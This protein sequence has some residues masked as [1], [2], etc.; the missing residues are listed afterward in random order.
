MP[1]TLA[2][3]AI[4]GITTKFLIRKSDYLWIYL[5]CII[6]DFPWILRRLIQFISPSINGYFLQSYLIIQAS[7][8]V[9]ILLGLIFSFTS[10]NIYRTFLI[11]SL[12]SILHLL[13]DPIQIKWANGVHLFAPFSW[14]L[15][16]YGIFWPENIITYI[17]TF[18]GLLFFLININSSIKT[19]FKLEITLN[20]IILIL[21][22]S[23]IYFL[24]PL[25]FIQNIKEKDCH[26]VSTLENVDE[27]VGKYA[28]F[29]RKSVNYDDFSNNYWIESF[30][31][32]RIELL[33]IKNLA[34]NNVSVKGRFLTEN[35]FYVEEFHENWEIFRDGASY[36]GI[37]LISMLWFFKILNQFK[38]SSKKSSLPSN[39]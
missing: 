12:G 13:L 33:N 4:N 24:S 19:K 6:P 21:L 39:V 23:T 10:K 3:I 16:N 18:S 28:E 26:F 14:E 9:S 5:G 2:H 36:L 29:D 1:N 20:R 8:A 22:L 38:Y 15:I 11:L 34:S 32:D 27:R 35:R 7:L 37:L 31:R 30:N 17:L 25:L